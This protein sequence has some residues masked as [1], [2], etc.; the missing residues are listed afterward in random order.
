MYKPEWNDVVG[1]S[2]EVASKNEWKT[3]FIG[4]DKEDLLQ[5]AFLVFFNCVS[6]NN[7]FD[8]KGHFITFY[9]RS[10]LNKIIDLI[11]YKKLEKEA[12]CQFTL[13][14]E[15]GES[16]LENTFKSG[17]SSD[18]STKL[19][20]APEHI[21]NVIQLLSMMNINR[22]TNKKLCNMLGYDSNSIDLIEETKNYFKN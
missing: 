1:I 20:E 12:V 3:I 8:H 10:L 17:D 9:K 21:K 15:E 4:L 2:K 5:E 7:N 11:K 13:E 19:S 22:I 6:K 16:M 18:F 14:N